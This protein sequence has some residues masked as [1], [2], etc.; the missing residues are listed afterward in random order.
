MTEKMDELL[1]RREEEFIIHCNN[2]KD[3]LGILNSCGSNKNGD[4][5][6]TRKIH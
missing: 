5:K 3:V 6:V 2:P 4:N 1:S